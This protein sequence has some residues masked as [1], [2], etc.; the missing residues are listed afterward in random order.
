LARRHGLTLL[1]DLRSELVGHQTVDDR[2]RVLQGVITGLER[3]T[4]A[5]GPAFDALVE[6]LALLFAYSPDEIR[7]A[8]IAKAPVETVVDL[9]RLAH[10]LRADPDRWQPADL[11]RVLAYLPEGVPLGLYGRGPVW[12]Y[13][14][15]ALLTPPAPFYQFDVRLGWVG[16]PALARGEEAPEGPLRIQILYRGDHIRLEA[17]IKGS[18][19]DYAEAQDLV[20]PAIQRETGIVLSGKLP[21]WLWTALALAYRDMR[22][23]AVYQPQQHNRAVVAFSS[24][25]GV[26]PGDLVVSEP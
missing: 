26:R 9:A 13:A 7:Q 20:V 15:V 12:L 10:T 5:S 3:G 4:L 8:H 24:G 22:W 17:S 1:A 25:G 14:A 6:R 11:P 19:L 18:Y 16:P 21:L 23:V 2:G